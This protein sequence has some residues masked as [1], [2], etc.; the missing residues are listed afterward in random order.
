MPC[1]KFHYQFITTWMRLVDKME[2]EGVFLPLKLT[3]IWLYVTLNPIAVSI[4]PLVSSWHLLEK[5][6]SLVSVTTVPV[7]PFINLIKILQTN[8]NQ[9]YGTHISH[10][11][12][13]AIYQI[14]VVFIILITI[15]LN[16]FI[17]KS[18]LLFCQSKIV[19][20]S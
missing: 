13:W 1:S 12:F 18:N 15:H 2:Y 16:T 3:H 20:K 7:L 6:F 5:C 4:L 8:K 17:W 11:I 10:Q 19:Q 14:V 9:T